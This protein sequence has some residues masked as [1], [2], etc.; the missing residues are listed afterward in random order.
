MGTL[1]TWTRLGE[2]AVHPQVFDELRFSL[3]KRG[4]FCLVDFALYSWHCERHYTPKWIYEFCEFVLSVFLHAFD[5]IFVTVLWVCSLPVTPCPPGDDH[6]HLQDMAAERQHQETGLSSKGAMGSLAW[7]D[8]P[9]S[10][11]AYN[12]HLQLTPFLGESQSLPSA[13]TP[14]QPLPRLCRPL[15]WVSECQHWV[16]LLTGSLIIL[17]RPFS[18]L[19][20]AW[21]PT[22]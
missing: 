8:T 1:R 2:V 17:L 11:A 19:S 6:S 20:S 18:C 4:V 5:G 13:Q 16:F 9:D 10:Q 14:F 22:C 12:S 21:I 3:A 15:Q 7:N